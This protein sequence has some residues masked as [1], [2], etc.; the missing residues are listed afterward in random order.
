MK[1]T[2]SSFDS[3]N[4]SAICEGSGSVWMQMP[5]FYTKS[6]CGS[7]KADLTLELIANADDNAKM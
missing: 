2:C 5:L 7:F 3:D 4:D 1:C 6:K